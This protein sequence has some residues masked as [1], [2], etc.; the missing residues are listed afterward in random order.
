MQSYAGGDYGPTNQDMQ[1]IA[2]ISCE[3]NSSS[4]S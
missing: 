4:R 3:M 2:L 1:A